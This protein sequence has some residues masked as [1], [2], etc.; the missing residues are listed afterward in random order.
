MW[1]FCEFAEE[2]CEHGRLDRSSAGAWDGLGC[3]RNSDWG[4]GVSMTGLLARRLFV[5]F[6]LAASVV[7]VV[8]TSASAITRLRTGQS[9]TRS[10]QRYFDVRDATRTAVG[11]RGVNSA[12]PASRSAL[13][14]RRTLRDRF[15]RQSHLQVDPITGTPRSFQ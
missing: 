6:V 15:G 9:A 12:G 2:A 8:T 7:A 4:D 5:V 13:A 1:V 10:L 11:R 3:A 14:A